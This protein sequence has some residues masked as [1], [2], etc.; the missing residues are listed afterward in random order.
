MCACSGCTLLYCT[1]AGSGS[2]GGFWVDDACDHTLRS[3]PRL[4]EASHKHVFFMGHWGD[5]TAS[6]HWLPCSE[7]YWTGTHSRFTALLLRE[8]S[9]DQTRVQ[10]LLKII[11]NMYWIC[12]I[13]VCLLQWKQHIRQIKE[14]IRQRY[15]FILFITS[16]LSIG[17]PWLSDTIA[18]IELI[19]QFSN[20]TT[21]NTWIQ[22]NWDV[23]A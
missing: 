3:A 17:L 6:G 10:I 1:L 13:W 18:N 14:T 8:S 15:L 11:K 20:I 19:F 4:Q 16:N 2:Q 9:A 12:L 22:C 23:I 7:T 21:S 5:W